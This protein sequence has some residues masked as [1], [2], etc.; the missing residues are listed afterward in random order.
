M[1]IP[2][3]EMRSYCLTLLWWGVLL[4]LVTG[5]QPN[6]LPGAAQSPL[7]RGSGGFPRICAAQVDLDYIWDADPEQQARNLDLLVERVRRLGVNTVL[8]Q[9]F[10]DPDGNDRAAALYFPNQYLPMRADL[11]PEAV[12]RLRQSGV[13][14]YAWMP[15]LGFELTGDGEDLFVHGADRGGNRP[16]HRLSPFHPGARAIIRGIY[17]DLARSATVDGILFHDDGVLSDFEDASPAAL[18]VYRRNGFPGRIADIRRDPALF[19]RWSRFK[20]RYLVNLSLELLDLVRKSQPWIRSGR[21]LFAQT[22]LQP[23][24]QQWLAQSLPLFL[25][26]YDYVFLMAM[27]WM[28]QA[29]RPEAWLRSLADQTLDQVL[30]PARLVFELQSVDW[31]RNSRIPARTLAAQMRLLARAGARSFAYYPD[32][33]FLDHPQTKIMGPLFR[34]MACRRQGC[35]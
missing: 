29:A 8:L 17:A 25:Q 5:C 34:A 11:F 13:A 1:S 28:E 2:I 30:E 26:A 20:S 4:G 10:A 18:T 23:E 19:A 3:A 14:V 6:R 35:R 32:D 21:N 7:D 12:R 31:R 15:L 24:S 16:T 9:G 33:P 22:V 27:P